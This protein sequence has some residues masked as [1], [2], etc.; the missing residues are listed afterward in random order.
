M[1]CARSVFELG[2]PRPVVDVVVAGARDYYLTARVFD[3]LGALRYLITDFY[4]GPGSACSCLRPVLQVLKRWKLPAKLLSRDA[5]LRAGQVHAANLAGLVSWW[6][7]RKATGVREAMHLYLERA[8]SL[9]RLA[10]RKCRPAPD[11]IVGYRMS[12]ELFAR[13][14]GRSAC[15]LCQMDGGSHE[16][17]VVREEVRRFPEWTRQGRPPESQRESANVQWLEEEAA[18]LKREWALSDWIVCLSEWCKTC[19]VAGGGEADKCVVIPLAFSPGKGYLKVKPSFRSNPFTIGFLGTLCIRKGTHRL[20]EAAARASRSV[21]VRVVLAGTN[22][23]NPAMLSKFSAVASHVGTIPKSQVP[24]FLSQV[25]VLA[26][27]SVS[28][29]FG[30]VQLE[31]MSAGVPV[32]STESSGAVVRHGTDGLIVPA[33]HTHSLA[34]AIVT[35]AQN[36][37]LC[38][39]MG[40]AARQRALE[41]SLE[42]AVESWGRLTRRACRPVRGEGLGI[43]GCAPRRAS[44]P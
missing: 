16:V 9:A 13:F 3:S 30:M 12:D 42:A 2:E 33:A 31:A 23:L 6:K 4:V 43:W 41:F 25:H 37:D 27:P 34:E 29:G 10:D 7:L 14:Q 19:V 40:E 11:A 35:M 26:L 20:L 44:N 17:R 21:P 8:R 32:I 38:S 24:R 1:T 15:I 18:R 5:G 36:R 39:R 28:E 22:E